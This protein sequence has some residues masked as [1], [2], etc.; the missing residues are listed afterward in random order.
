M[1]IVYLRG[2]CEDLDN[3]QIIGLDD[4][5]RRRI[6]EV[7]KRNICITGYFGGFKEILQ[8]FAENLPKPVSFLASVTK[9][10]RCL[11]ITSKLQWIS[12]ID[13]KNN[14]SPSASKII[15]ME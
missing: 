11:R 7:L 13:E 12:E 15:K 5:T 1:R 10:K 8:D 3:V 14:N 2:H 4:S 9:N 6:L